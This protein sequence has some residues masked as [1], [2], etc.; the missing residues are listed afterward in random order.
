MTTTMPDSF[1]FRIKDLHRAPPA[2]DETNQGCAASVEAQGHGFVHEAERYHRS[3][4]S[5]QHGTVKL[6]P[7][8]YDEIALSHPR[9][10]LTYIDEDD[11]GEVIT[12]C[13]PRG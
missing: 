7:S 1:Q 2:H 11:D 9:A 6:S 5:S 4:P 3:N 13:P 10:L 8:E 12:V